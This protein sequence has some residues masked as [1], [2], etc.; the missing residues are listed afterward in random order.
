[1]A[2]FIVS[3]V[4]VFLI[5]ILRGGLSWQHCFIIAIITAAVSALVELFTLG[6]FDTFTCPMAAASVI[7]P[8][9]MLF[10]G[11]PL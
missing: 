9:T 3:F 10:V 5:M 8:M 6:G 7:I 11:I 1:M 2:M 4:S